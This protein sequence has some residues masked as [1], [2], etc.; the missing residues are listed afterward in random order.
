MFRSRAIPA[1]GQLRRGKPTDLQLFFRNPFYIPQLL[2]LAI[3][4]GILERA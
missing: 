4:S 2:G 3:Q 1:P